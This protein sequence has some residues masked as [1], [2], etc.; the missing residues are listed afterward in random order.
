M[1]LAPGLPPP[2]NQRRLNTPRADV[3]PVGDLDP[4]RALPNQQ[5]RRQRSAA[6]LVRRLP[7]LLRNAHL[8]GHVPPDTG[9]HGARNRTGP[10]HA[11]LRFPPDGPILEDE[12]RDIRL[13]G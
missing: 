5:A 11:K 2:R 7:H 1:D 9:L 6:I 13:R 10:D 8:S 3:L 4:F 12:L